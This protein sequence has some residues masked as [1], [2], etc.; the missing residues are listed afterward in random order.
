MASSSRWKKPKVL[1]SYLRSKQKRP[2]SSGRGQK[3]RAVLSFPLSS[4]QSGIGSDFQQTEQE[5]GADFDDLDG[6]DDTLTHGRRRTHEVMHKRQVEAW[7]R[8]RPRLLDCF[9]ASLAMPP[10]QL[11]MSCPNHADFRCRECSS[12]AYYCRECCQAQHR[13][14]N[15]LHTPERWVNDHYVYS[16][17]ENVVIPLTH[18]C[19]SMYSEKVTVVSSKGNSFCLLHRVVRQQ[20][21]VHVHHAYVCLLFV[22]STAG[23]HHSVYITCCGCKSIA[24]RLLEV[25]LWPATPV[26]PKLAFTLDLMDI[27]HYLVLE[28]KASLHDI[29]NYLKAVGTPQPMVLG[30][31]FM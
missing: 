30:V 8:V 11:C 3:R 10:G 29:S 27:I 14:S 9:T 25:H 24:E 1:S 22:A 15:F 21:C 6:S 5:N 13:Y 28:C 4:S 12:L 23:Q 19:A 7:E 18:D 31:L 2:A 26:K 16:P 20:V 17:L